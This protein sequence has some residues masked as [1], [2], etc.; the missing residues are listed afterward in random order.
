MKLL[1][2]IGRFLL[3]VLI[4][5]NAAIILS[6]RTYLYKGISNTYL[7]GRSGPSIDEYQ[8]FD[9]NIVEA[10]EQQVWP[11]GKNYNAAQLPESLK[12]LNEELESIAF[13][14]IQHDSIRYEEYWDGY[15]PSST[16][17]SFSAAKT[18]VSIL[19]GI[20]IEEGYIKSEEQL[21]KDFF[22]QYDERLKI[23]HLLT[24]SS[25]INFD[26]HYKNPLAYPAQ[27]YFG[28]NLRPLTLS[29]EVKKEPGKEFR[30]LSGNTAL[31]AFIIKKATGRSISEYASEKLW[32]PMGANHH[33]FWSLDHKGGDEKAYC[34]FN[35][36]ARD[37]ARFGQLY[38]DSG[39]W[40]GEQ[41]V[42]SS[43]VLKSIQAAP[44]IDAELDGKKNDR[45]GYSWWLMQ[46][47]HLNIFYARG[48]LGQYI[49]VIPEKDMVIVRLGKK[50]AAT[51]DQGHPLD[52]YEYIDAA[53]AMYEKAL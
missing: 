40:K 2:K 34:C 11:Q 43:Y 8:I 4:L 39:K 53:L 52:V 7:K 37:F 47:H 51:Y 30:Y 13:L 21:V 42:P 28:K 45:Y 32:K 29:Y 5:L 27:A 22:P 24:M 12:K 15:T 26:E 41:L 33:A 23:K 17:N 35:A 16:T 6:G 18:F 9:N 36:N 48:I 25:G 50:R 49:I 19:C 14:I 10:G 20:A 44:L 31:L 3:I 1:K 38:L 46:D